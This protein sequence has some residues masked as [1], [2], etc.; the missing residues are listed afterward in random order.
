MKDNRTKV[1]AS[2]RGVKPGSRIEFIN[3]VTGDN[4]NGEYDMF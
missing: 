4:D 1:L 2:S 3:V